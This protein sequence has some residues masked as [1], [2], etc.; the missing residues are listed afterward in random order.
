MKQLIAA[1][2]AAFFAAASF[3]A[4]AQAPAPT[5]TTA[6]EKPAK[7]VKKAKKAKKAKKTDDTAAPAAATK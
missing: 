7:K 2:V 6:A 4:A 5:D 1:L 3:N